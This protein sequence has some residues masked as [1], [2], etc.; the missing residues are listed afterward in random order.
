M[1]AEGRRRNSAGML[2]A[3]ENLPPD[4]L[5]WR[6]HLPVWLPPAA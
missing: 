5:G 4:A 6:R 3:F 2:S 1:A